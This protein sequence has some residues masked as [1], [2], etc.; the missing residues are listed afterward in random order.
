M[1]SQA[2]RASCPSVCLNVLKEGRG[3]G[4]LRLTRAKPLKIAMSLA[5]MAQSAPTRTHAPESI[6]R[7]ETSE[8]ATT[9]A[10]SN[11]VRNPQTDI[12]QYLLLRSA[13][14]LS[15]PFIVRA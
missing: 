13:D 1:S 3:S 7:T 9:A 6:M 14:L 11:A 12:F 10:A 8:P 5:M 15:T 4:R 2:C